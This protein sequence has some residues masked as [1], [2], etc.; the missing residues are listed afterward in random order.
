[1]SKL[2]M[3]LRDYQKLARGQHAWPYDVAMARMLAS[4]IIA[5]DYPRS[6]S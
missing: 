6:Y 2:A 5:N 4:W 3:E 1:M